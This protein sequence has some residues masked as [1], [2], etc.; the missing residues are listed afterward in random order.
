MR[1]G[2]FGGMANNMYVFA[3]VFHKLGEE[4]IFIRDRFDNFTISQPIWE[5]NEIKLSNKDLFQIKN[6]GKLD[7]D[8]Y[9]LKEKW[10]PRIKLLDLEVN[11]SRKHSKHIKHRSL[12]PS[13]FKLDAVIDALNSND[14]NLICGM[15]PSLIAFNSIKPYFIMPHGSDVRLALGYTRKT[16]RGIFNRIFTSKLEKALKESYLKSKSIFTHGPSR[17]LSPLSRKDEDIYIYKYLK[18]NNLGIPNRKFYFK[19]ES[20]KSELRKLLN[21]NVNSKYVILVPSRIDFKV[22]GQDKLVNI[23]KGKRNDNCHY[24]F[25]GWGENYESIKKSLNKTNVSV[26]DKI[27]SKKLLY[28]LIYISDLVIDQFN[29]GHYG[30]ITQE[31]MMLGKP[32]MTYIFKNDYIQMAQDPPPLLNCKSEKDIKKFLD[33]ISKNN[34]DLKKIGKECYKWIEKRHNDKLVLKK[35]KNYCEI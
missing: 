28:K 21:I 12:I 35:F 24:I 29:L 2:F 13:N 10:V 33:E 34:I 7:W 23:I 32:V 16:Q 17:L 19:Y 4:I 9:E 31:A 6:W 30:T 20:K 5:D 27:V 25:F 3:K 8:N 22:K 1:I 14:V 11:K 18:F 15:V 26:L